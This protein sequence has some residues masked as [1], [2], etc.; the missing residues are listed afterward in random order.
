[1]EKQNNFIEYTLTLAKQ[2]EKIAYLSSDKL[3]ILKQNLGL[4]F[5]Q[6]KSEL[7]QDDDFYT[8]FNYY[9]SSE[10]ERNM[11]G[12]YGNEKNK[13]EFEIDEKKFEKDKLKIELKIEYLDNSE[14]N[15]LKV[16]D[17]WEVLWN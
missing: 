15:E 17:P 2:K 10:D 4:Y 9:Y 12:E 5:I 11:F 14:G 8:V 7:K 6:E 13:I 1:M 16:V 3:K